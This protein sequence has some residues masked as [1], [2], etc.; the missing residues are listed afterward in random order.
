M[1]QKV[2]SFDFG[3][4]SSTPGPGAYNPTKLLS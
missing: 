4:K 1:G 2:S 3:N